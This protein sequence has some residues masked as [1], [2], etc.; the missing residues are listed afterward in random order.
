MKSSHN[1]FKMLSD[2]ASYGVTSNSEA[3]AEG[4]GE[5]GWSMRHLG[6]LC[7]YFLMHG[8][9]HHSTTAFL[10]LLLID[11]KYSIIIRVCE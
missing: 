11:S 6:V 3:K 8:C 10:Q 1:D 4:E 9:H 2:N 7:L 5:A